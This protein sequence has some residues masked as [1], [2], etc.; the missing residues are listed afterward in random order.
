MLPTPPVQMPRERL[1]EP[2]REDG[3]PIFVALRLADRQFPSAD[4]L[5]AREPAAPRARQRSLQYVTCS[6]Q[7][8]HFFRH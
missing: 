4:S 2:R 5:A 8:A 3:D 6:Q 7:S 1:G